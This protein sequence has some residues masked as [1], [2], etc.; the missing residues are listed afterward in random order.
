MNRFF[1]ITLLG[2]FVG[3]L[4]F[5]GLVP[6]EALA[7]HEV[8]PY[9]P[10]EIISPHPG[11]TESAGTVNISWKPFPGYAYYSLMVFNSVGTI[12]CATYNSIGTNHDCDNLVAGVHTAM[13][14]AIPS[15]SGPYY[16]PPTGFLVQ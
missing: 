6:T 15:G 16:G 12:V 8:P 14:I 10:C 9:D 2:V 3:G 1:I 5:V 11:G 13:V 7:S 4:L